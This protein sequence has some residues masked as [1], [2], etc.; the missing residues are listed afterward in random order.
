MITTEKK[1]EI[2]DEMLDFLIK[3]IGINYIKEFELLDKR[4]LLDVL[5]LMN[6]TSLNNDYF[7]GLQDKLLK[8]ENKKFINVYKLKFVKGV[9]ETDAEL[10]AINSDLVVYFSKNLIS[11]QI[12]SS[13]DNCV[14][15]KAG[16]QVNIEYSKALKE[17]GFNVDFNRVYFTEG[18]NLPC[19]YLGK[20]VYENDVNLDCLK[21]VF[22][23]LKE[24][25]L[26]TVYFYLNNTNLK[27]EDIVKF[28]P[29]NIKIIIKS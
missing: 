29:K 16:V 10:T 11:Q 23:F 17:N 22:E 26:E 3:E 2:I 5:R 6:S 18:Y 8:E 4:E 19:Q 1:N 13:L 28:K 27:L 9:A 25:E 21:Q 14:V 12:D 7:L 24:Y 20:V 15:L